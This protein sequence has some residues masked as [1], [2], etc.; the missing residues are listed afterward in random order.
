MA[1]SGLRRG[2]LSTQK[3][4]DLRKIYKHNSYRITVYKEEHEQYITY[5]TPECAKEKTTIYNGVLILVM[6]LDSVEIT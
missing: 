1:S 3:L 4:K 2:E 5:C 6:Y